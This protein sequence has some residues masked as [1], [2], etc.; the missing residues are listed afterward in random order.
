MKLFLLPALA[1]AL[2]LGA[3]STE[4]TA[5]GGDKDNNVENSDPNA[6]QVSFQVNGMNCEACPPSVKTAVAGALGVDASK[7]KVD[8]ESKTCT[9]EGAALTPEQEEAIATALAAT[10]KFSIAK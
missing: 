9:V 2:V 4:A 5:D 3:C 10:N 6:Q 7:V 8:L 1:G